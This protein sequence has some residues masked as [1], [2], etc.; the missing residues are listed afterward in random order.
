MPPFHDGSAIAWEF[1]IKVCATGGAGNAFYNNG[2]TVSSPIRQKSTVN[3]VSDKIL[4]LSWLTSLLLLLIA[5][6]LMYISDTMQTCDCEVMSIPFNS[7]PLVHPDVIEV[8]IQSHLKGSFKAI[9]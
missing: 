1:S 8:N 6:S 4:V 2:Q 7:V 9:S 3:V 5:G